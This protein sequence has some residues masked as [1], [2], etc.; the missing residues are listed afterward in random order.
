MYALGVREFPPSLVAIAQHV[1]NAYVGSDFVRELIESRPL[2]SLNDGE[3][4]LETAVGIYLG[5]DGR[6]KH[7]GVVVEAMR[8]VSK[9]GTGHLWRHEA[10]ETPDLYGDEIR[11]FEPPKPEDVLGRFAHYV[12]R[13]IGERVD[14]A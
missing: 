9:W 8:V 4:A 2:R 5:N 1:R 14:L 6:P 3:R 13:V 11:Y 12:E 7:A 10:F